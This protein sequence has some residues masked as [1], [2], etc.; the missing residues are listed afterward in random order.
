MKGN[1]PKPQSH[2]TSVYRSESHNSWPVCM[3][4]EREAFWEGGESEAVPKVSCLCL[5]RQDGIL[6]SR[7]RV[8]SAVGLQ[9]NP[10]HGEEWASQSRRQAF[11]GSLPTVVVSA[12]ERL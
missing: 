11:W 8:A 12:L 1:N 2:S 9:E 3:G 6:S 7:D 5:R 4:Q 10:W